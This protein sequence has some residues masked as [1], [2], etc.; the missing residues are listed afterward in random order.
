ME[1]TIVPTF[2]FQK[3]LPRLPIPDLEKSCNLYLQSLSALRG[4]GDDLD[5]AKRMIDNFKKNEGAQ[6]H[7]LLIQSQGL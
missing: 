1:D 5:R 6:L 7:K 3:S 4:P 2:H